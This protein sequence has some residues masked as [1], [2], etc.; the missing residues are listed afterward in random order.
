MSKVYN[1]TKVLICTKQGI[2]KNF[3]SS[4][5]ALVYAVQKISLRLLSLLIFQERR[6]RH[7]LYIVDEIKGVLSDFWGKR[8]LCDNIHNVPK[9]NTSKK[10]TTITGTTLKET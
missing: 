1:G 4:L 8:G 7:K 5:S 3:Y 2:K 6:F 10:S 9:G